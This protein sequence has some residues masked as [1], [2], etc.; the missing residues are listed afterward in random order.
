MHTKSGVY[1]FVFEYLP[2][3][4]YVKL[5][6]PNSIT[7]LIYCGMQCDFATVNQKLLLLS[8]A[9]ICTYIQTT[10][11]SYESVITHILKELPPTPHHNRT[12]FINCNL[13]LYIS[14]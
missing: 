9:K 7:K 13:L 12:T 10:Y 14:I 5:L 1:E 11:K 6:V 8:M 4:I 3:I 2:I